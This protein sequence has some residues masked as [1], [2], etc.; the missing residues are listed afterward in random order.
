METL[1]KGLTF[2]FAA[3]ILM[4]ATGSLG[5]LFLALLLAPILCPLGCLICYGQ[6]GPRSSEL[7]AR[8]L[9]HGNQ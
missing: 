1:M 9:R 5:F 8:H 6:P 4:L 3:A 2:L 7:R